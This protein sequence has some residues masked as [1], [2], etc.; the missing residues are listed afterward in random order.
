MPSPWSARP[1]TPAQRL[2][3]SR[4]WCA[5]CGT[6]RAARNERGTGVRQRLA[7]PRHR[8]AANFLLTDQAIPGCCPAGGTT[9]LPITS[10]WEWCAPT[11]RHEMIVLGIAGA[12]GHDA[13]AALVINGELVAMAEEER[14]TR[15]RHAW[16]SVPVESAAYCLATAGITLAD[17]D[18]LAT[19]W[20]DEDFDYP[21]S[22]LHHRLLDHRYFAGV[23]RPALEKVPH[24]LAHAAAAYYTSGFSEAAIVSA[25]GVGDRVS[26]TIAH[27]RDGSITALR[28][29]AISDSLGLFYLGLTNYLGFHQGQEGKVMGLASYADP[30][31]SWM[32][33]ML[34]DEG[35]HSGLGTMGA[36]RPNYGG[37]VI[38]AW[39]GRLTDRFGPARPAAYAVAPSTARL[40]AVLKPTDWHYHAAAS[41]QHVLETT[42]LHLVGLAVRETGCHDVVLGGGVALNCTANGAIWNSGLVERLSIFPASDDAGT[43]AGAALAVAA[44]AGERSKQPLTTAALGPQFDDGIIRSA[45]DDV[46]ASFTESSDIADAVAGLLT[47]GRIVGWFQGRLEVGPRALGQRSVLASPV[48][49]STHQQVNSIKDREQWRPLAP[50]LSSEA[51]DDYLVDPGPSRFMLSAC[52]VREPQ[53]S[54]IPAVVHVDGSC[55]PQ[56]LDAE[57]SPPFRRLLNRL[58]ARGHPEVV[59]NTSFNLADEPIVSSPLDAIRSFYASGLDCLA[60]GSAL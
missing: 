36:D 28:E 49:R 34:N 51:A 12:L 57:A 48:L 27:G 25:D 14:F 44:A 7:G 15:R 13:S 39:Q 22:A 1:G 43:S 16:N 47:E 24:A 21:E 53:R 35:Y 2:N 30:D 4:I 29:F 32:P 26:T 33:F 56:I 54:R 46:G 58:A 6:G 41:G 8:D 9:A 50:S 60:I 37:P 40:T 31:R 20:T 17:V 59:L 3:V 55:R 52:P 45:L 38:R 5:S 23:P 11:R 42:M 18:V 19:G 10:W